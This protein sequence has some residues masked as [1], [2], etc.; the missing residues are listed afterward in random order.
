MWLSSCS[1]SI[2]SISGNDG[3]IVIVNLAVIAFHQQSF[4]FRFIFRF[5]RDGHWFAMIP[6]TFNAAMKRFWVFPYLVGRWW[7]K[8][9]HLEIT[10]N[11]ILLLLIRCLEE[12]V[13]KQDAAVRLAKMNKALIRET[14]YTYNHVF[15]YIIMLNSKYLMCNVIEN[16]KLI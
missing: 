15:P 9:N 13:S 10:I 11:N 6:K 7:Y 1:F 2:Q 14:K 8:I 12:A 4:L 3:C 5:P 16:Q